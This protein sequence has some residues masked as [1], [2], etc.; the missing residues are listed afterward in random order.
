M[1]ES[2]EPHT[3]GGPEVGRH[4]LGP[5]VVGRRVVVRHLVRGET[6]PSGGPALNDVLGTCTG[7]AGGVVTLTREDGTV[8]EVAVADIV[9]GKPVPPRPSVRHRVGPRAA[10]LH[11][12]AM[13]PDVQLDH[14]G[15]WVLRTDPGGTVARAN[16]VLAIGDPGVPVPDAADAVRRW[17]AGRGRPVWAQVVAGSDVDRSLLDLGWVPARPGEADTLFQ[18]APVARALRACNAVSGAL[19]EPP[20]AP[21]APWTP[22]Y[23]GEGARV[24]VELLGPDGAAVAEG[25]AALDDDWVGVHGVHTDPAR[26]R[27]G[28]AVAVMAELLDWAAAD[29]ATTAYLQVRADN[30]PALGLY[31]RLGFVT[32]H[33]YRYLVAP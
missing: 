8:V 2:P 33:A 20:G 10:H 11:G 12:L 21:Q 16:S 32:H 9:S 6:G 17:Y 27:R 31:E 29:G 4:L 23:S 5:H 28:L 22:R 14:L 25:R 3:V 1:R 13:W 24:R 30:P 7:W 19:G 15:E 26:R 18:I